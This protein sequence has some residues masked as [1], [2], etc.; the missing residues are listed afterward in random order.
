[1]EWLLKFRKACAVSLKF[2]LGLSAPQDTMKRE[3]DLLDFR[4]LS[5]LSNSVVAFSGFTGF[6][7]E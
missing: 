2:I 3:F 5:P 4:P 6:Q 1:M 7:V